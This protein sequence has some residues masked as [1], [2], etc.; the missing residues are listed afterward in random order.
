MKQIITSPTRINTNTGRESLIDYIWLNTDIINAGILPGISDHFSTYVHLRSSS[1]AARRY[2]LK[3][4]NQKS[5]LVMPSGLI[6]SVHTTRNFF[7]EMYS[8]A[9]NASPVSRIF[10]YIHFFH[11]IFKTS[12]FKNRAYSCPRD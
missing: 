10:K 6:M 9:K 11:N 4:E 7:P 3:N 12:K 1:S 8:V 2:P 5:G